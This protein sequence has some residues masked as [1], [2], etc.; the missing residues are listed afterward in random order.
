MIIVGAGVGGLVCGIYLQ[1]AGLRV[2]IFEKSNHPGGC[3]TSFSRQGFSFDV[4]VRGV[5]GCNEKGPLGKVFGELDLHKDVK[6]LRSGVFDI[7]QTDEYKVPLSHAADETEET[8]K[9]LFPEEARRIVEFFRLLKTDNFLKLYSE[10]GNKTYEDLIGA[11]FKTPSLKHFWNMLR[12]DTGLSPKTTSALAGFIL[13]RGYI[14]DGG[15]YPAGGMQALA[16]GLAGRFVSNGGN[17]VLSD[18]VKKIILERG[19]A[20]GIITEKERHAQARYIISNSDATHTYLQLIGPEKLPSAFVTRTKAMIPSLAAFIVYLGLNKKL[21]SVVDPCCAVWYSPS[22]MAD[23][24]Y[25]VVH[26]KK[27]DY[28]QKTVVCIFPSFQDPTM[29]P[30]G[31]ESLYMYIGAPFKDEPFWNEHKQPFMENMIDRAERL[32]PGLRQ[33]IIVQEA[34]TPQTIYRWTGNRGGASRGWACTPSQTH[35]SIISEES[36]IENLYLAGHWTTSYA[37][38]GG[39]ALAAYSG[40]KVAKLICKRERIPWL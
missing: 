36:F 13:A 26:T 7:I 23:E 31:C 28:N 5:V 1:Q 14:I 37:G 39:V 29:A 22:Y 25:N 35:P 38:H 15:Y 19:K 8:L 24:D 12:A 6:L 17:L 27:L 4:G 3:C 10:W 18:A 2:S 9:K 32:I 33:S 30:P 21:A 40:R 20:T 34:A 16:D 11:Y